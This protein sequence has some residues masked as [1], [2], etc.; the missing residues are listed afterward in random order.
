M[1]AKLEAAW[2]DFQNRPVASPILG[3]YNS[4]MSIKR[5]EHMPYYFYPSG[6]KV[7]SIE[8]RMINFLDWL[9]DA[10]EESRN[11]HDRNKNFYERSVFVWNNWA[12]YS[13]P[14]VCN[15]MF[16]G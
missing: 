4:F 6:V 1:E 2:R 8:D 12:R 3:L 11:P 13:N 9:C 15:A 10:H 16:D 7:V 14:T 5:Y